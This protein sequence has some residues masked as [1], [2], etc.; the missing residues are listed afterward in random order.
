M[1]KKKPTHF[2]NSTQNELQK[3]LLNPQ[4]AAM[5]H[6]LSEKY[7]SLKSLNGELVREVAA[8]RHEVKGLVEKRKSL[9]AELTRSHSVVE[10][11]EKEIGC[12]REREVRLGEEMAA[13]K[14]A[15][16]GLEEGNARVR[17]ENEGLVREREVAVMRLKGLERELEDGLR[18]KRAIEE[19]KGKE[20]EGLEKRISVLGEEIRREREAAEGV[21][22]EKSALEKDQKLL[23]N[24]A[25]KLRLLVDDWEQK[26]VK[27][28][29]IVMEMKSKYEEAVNVIEEK[30]KMISSMGFELGAMRISVDESKEMIDGLKKREEEL[31]K[32]KVELK[33]ER[34]VQSLK[35]KGLEEE[36]VLLKADVSV[37]RENE[38]KLKLKL[39]EMEQFN[40]EAVKN[41]EELSVEFGA[42]LR[43]KEEKERAVETLEKGLLIAKEQIDEVSKKLESVMRCYEELISEKNELEQTKTR[44]EKDFDVL[45]EEMIK[46]RELLSSLQAS[47]E[48]QLREIEHLVSKI[49]RCKDSL[50]I[51][52]LERDE[53]LKAVD[54]LTAVKNEIEQ[55]KFRLEKEI[56]VLQE[57]ITGLKEALSVSQAANADQVETNKQ[58][59]SE[60]TQY[61]ESLD[62]A[63]VEREK[64][65]K[66]VDELT[67]VKIQLERVKNTLENDIAGLQKEATVLK[68]EVSALQELNANKMEENSQLLAKVDD[69]NRELEVAVS[70]RDVARKALDDE[71]KNGVELRNEVVGLSKKLEEAEKE[72]MA[73]RV[74]NESL[75]GEKG[76]LESANSKLIEEKAM[77]EDKLAKTN[78]KL[79]D[80]HDTVK[81]KEAILE[82]LQE[83][84][85]RTADALSS[86][87]SDKNGMDDHIS[88]ERNM[89]DEMLRH[90][91]E[92]EAIESAFKSREAMVEEMKQEMKS[93]QTS[94]VQARKKKGFWAMVSSATTILAA[95]MSLAYAARVR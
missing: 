64:A 53:A 27:E 65:L 62:V 69:L 70:N 33:R 61:K 36:A 66:D 39:S 44:L 87:G 78:R 95:V 56:L 42:L 3:T 88:S 6:G 4:S 81:S 22:A 46:G 43:E 84:L 18:V 10:G 35:L 93:L 9:E 89:G 90:I 37:F 34:D 16:E 51:A 79:D 20:I 13:M 5:E 52:T 47:N 19:A 50:G 80:L 76:D 73:M 83:M 38:E 23:V 49:N 55:T 17:K 29:E 45:Q 24:E 15:I 72:L 12:L 31:A 74:T 77:V 30:E 40:G 67:S 85:K 91:A 57:K 54:E 1:A 32:E 8:R 58:L 71:R 14:R 11:L 59:I 60:V 75:V 86:K 68:G 82:N 92:L 94:V 28:A 25:E 41:W 2:P 7:A 63:N 21:V 26:A 48:A